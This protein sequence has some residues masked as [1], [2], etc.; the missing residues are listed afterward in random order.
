MKKIADILSADTAFAQ[1]KRAGERI[2]DM[3][4]VILQTLA[5]NGLDSADCEIAEFNDGELHLQSASAAVVFRIRQIL[6]TLRDS[7]KISGFSV[8][9]IRVSVATYR[10]RGKVSPARQK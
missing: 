8:A 4:A 9:A 5:E 2:S 7:L 6:P 1:I 10:R 3:H